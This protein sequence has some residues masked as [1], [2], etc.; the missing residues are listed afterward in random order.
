MGLALLAELKAELKGELAAKA[1]QLAIEYD[2]QP[3]FDAGHV[4]KADAATRQRA[5]TELRQRGLAVRAWEK[6]AYSLI[7]T[8]AFAPASTR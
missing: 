7:S 3:P 4:S 8:L 6:N 5:T 2:P 1:A